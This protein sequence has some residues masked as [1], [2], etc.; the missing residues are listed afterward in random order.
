MDVW[1]LGWGMATSPSFEQAR[2]Y[3][4]T[5]PQTPLLVLVVLVV[6]DLLVV[7]VLLVLL[8]LVLVL[9][10]LVHLRHPAAEPWIRT[11]QAG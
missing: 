7:L 9:V 4:L 8:V 5:T 10:L 1:F 11:A 6:L 3:H 2:L